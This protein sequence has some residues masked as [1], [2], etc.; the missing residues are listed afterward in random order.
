MAIAQAGVPDAYEKLY[1]R[2]IEQFV[3][4]YDAEPQF[5]LPSID[6]PIARRRSVWLRGDLMLRL[7]AIAAAY[8][9]SVTR[10]ID[11]AIDTYVDYYTRG[12][13][14]KLIATLASTAQKILEA[15][16][17]TGNVLGERER[18]ARKLMRTGQA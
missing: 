13:D 5:R 1:D 6:G 17:A 3:D 9:C 14:P 10:L 12:I 16:E 4:L 18:K 8:P 15:S 11:T 7:E 2:A